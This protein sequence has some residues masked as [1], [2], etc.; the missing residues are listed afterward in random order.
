M[1]VGWFRPETVVRTS[2]FRTV[3][4]GG[5]G[6]AWIVQAK[7]QMPNPNIVSNKKDRRDKAVIKPC[8]G[9][10]I[11]LILLPLIPPLK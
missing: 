3:I 1:L 4:E 8:L 9:A 2:R 5:G 10:V 11:T 7:A 6:C